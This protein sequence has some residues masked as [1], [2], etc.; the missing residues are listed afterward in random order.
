MRVGFYLL[1]GPSS[2]EAAVVALVARACQAGQRVLVVAEPAERL[3]AL[4]RALWQVPGQFLAH[5]LA[6]EGHEHRQPVLLSSTCAAANGA[7]L[8]ILAD[9]VWRDE[10]L[11]F[12]RALLVFGD[13]QRAANRQQWTRFEGREDIDREFWRHDGQGWK[14]QA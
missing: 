11:T 8:V 12:D 7:R 4:S 1:E 10:A 2:A 3:T 6:G 5:G 14:K 13:D 9:G